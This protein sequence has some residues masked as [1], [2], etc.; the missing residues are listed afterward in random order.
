[1]R[2]VIGRQT[3]QYR[4]GWRKL[5]F[6][7]GR[8]RGCGQCVCET[9]VWMRTLPTPQRIRRPSSYGT[10]RCCCSAISSKCFAPVNSGPLSSTRGLKSMGCKDK[11]R[12]SLCTN[13]SSVRTVGAFF[14]H[15][16]GTFVSEW[17]V[18]DVERTSLLLAFSESI[19]ILRSWRFRVTVS[20]VC[21]F[22]RICGRGSSWTRL[23]SY[24]NRDQHTPI[25][26]TGNNNKA[27]YMDHRPYCWAGQYTAE[28]QQGS[29]VRSLRSRLAPR[30]AEN[31]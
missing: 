7:L 29:S 4:L 5:A 28:S 23:G 1:M 24:Q 17:M 19:D 20:L 9:G 31:N 26:S 6:R 2:G 30:S 22:P 14:R 27:Y 21:R 25:P 12:N 3:N 13:A 10:E 11:I 8:E 15:I 18:L 16:L